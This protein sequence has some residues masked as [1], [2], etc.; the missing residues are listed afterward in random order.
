M[1]INR[2]L[3]RKVSKISSIIFLIMAASLAEV[4]AGEGRRPGRFGGPAV[5]FW[6]PA[7]LRLPAGRDGFLALS[8]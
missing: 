8:Y 7:R 4:P 6:L 2:V 1:V 3:K 5:F